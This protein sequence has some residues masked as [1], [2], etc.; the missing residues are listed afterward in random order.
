M[1]TRKR[2]VGRNQ[3]KGG[4]AR[5]GGHS[6]WFAVTAE[7]EAAARSMGANGASKTVATASGNT[8]LDSA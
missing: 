7:E 4:E 6:A 1:G 2:A 3:E 8:A 5:A